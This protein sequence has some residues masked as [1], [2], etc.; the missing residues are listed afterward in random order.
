[1][2]LLDILSSFSDDELASQLAESEL[3]QGS[4]PDPE[5]EAISTLIL[6]EVQRR[7]LL[8]ENPL[9]A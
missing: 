7:G 8:K 5:L 9:Q 6:M 2:K 1:M 3:R 4:F